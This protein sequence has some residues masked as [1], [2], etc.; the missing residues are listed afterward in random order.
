MA[1]RHDSPAHDG[2]LSLGRLASRAL[3]VAVALVQIAVELAVT[4]VRDVFVVR[5]RRSE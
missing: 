5:A 1:E 2:G 4:A 3:F